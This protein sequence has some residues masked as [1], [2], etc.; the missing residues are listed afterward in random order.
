MVSGVHARYAHILRGLIIVSVLGSAVASLT[1]ASA[2][3]V[4]V[5]RDN[6]D[7]ANRVNMV[8]VG[9]GYIDTEMSKFAADAES[10]VEG[11]FA[12]DP[13]K[14]YRRYFNVYR[15]DVVSA[16]SGATHPESV[17]PVVR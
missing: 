3:P 15:V 9:D 1:Q 11:F 6:G 8:I 14:E 5:I 12:Q 4:T 13:F 7:P 16:Q 10:A 17:P 2:D